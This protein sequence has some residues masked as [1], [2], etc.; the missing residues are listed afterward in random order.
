MYLPKPLYEAKPYLYLLTGIFV[1]LTWGF[2]PFSVIGS[3]ALV[4]GGLFIIYLRYI[5]RKKARAAAE[6]ASAHAT[7]ET[8]DASAKAAG[9]QTS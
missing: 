5:Y 4:V 6:V 8:V 9:E 1:A 7:I 3:A 2:N